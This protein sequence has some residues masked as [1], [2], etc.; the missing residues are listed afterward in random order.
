MLCNVICFLI[1]FFFVPSPFLKFDLD[2]SR[3][4][5]GLGA[6]R[7]GEAGQGSSAEGAEAVGHLVS[8][9]AAGGKAAGRVR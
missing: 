8:R 7:A 1:Y 9:G 4:A 2:A 3:R 5:R 6:V